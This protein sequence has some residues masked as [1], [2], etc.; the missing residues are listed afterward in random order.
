MVVFEHKVGIVL[1][2]IAIIL[3]YVSH[4]YHEKLVIDLGGPQQVYLI[5]TC[6]S[7]VFL[8]P[9]TLIIISID[10]L[11][12]REHHHMMTMHEKSSIISFLANID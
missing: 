11:L 5:A 12:V 10:H 8:V 2:I 7:A 4:S 1:L 6:L 9:T 3:R